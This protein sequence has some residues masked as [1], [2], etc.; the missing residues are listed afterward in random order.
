MVQDSFGRKKITAFTVT[1][2]ILGFIFLIFF[3]SLLMQIFALML[4]WGYKEIVYSILYVHSNELLVNPFRKHSTN[5]YTVIACL[6]GIMANFLTYYIDNYKDMYIIFFVG[7]L[8]YTILVFFLPESPSFLLK[9][10]KTTELKKVILDI[11]DTNRLPV[12]KI[13]SVMSDLECVIESNFN[14]VLISKMK[15]KKQ[16]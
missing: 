14:L 16:K 7:F 10:S 4:I 2:L 15:K 5:F 12:E 1:F 11:A 9:N 13:S 8:I 3:E 6:G